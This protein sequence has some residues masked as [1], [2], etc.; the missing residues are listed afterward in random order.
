MYFLPKYVSTIAKSCYFDLLK[1][2]L[3]NE[4][5]SWLQLNIR[6]EKT[7]SSCMYENEDVIK[8]VRLKIAEI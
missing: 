1:C 4:C 7:K 6:H 5:P 8:V 3:L 2:N